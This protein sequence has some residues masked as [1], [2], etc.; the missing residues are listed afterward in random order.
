[1]SAG[2]DT[3]MYVGE[4]PWHNLGHKYE[5]AP[6]TSEEI[7]R[8]AS[9]DWTVNTAKM[10]T[11][12][13][14]DVLNYHAIYREDNNAI[15]GVVNTHYPKLV[16]NVESF[17]AF[18][19][20]LGNEVEV[21]TAAS[22]G[23]GER[24]FGCFKISQGY[25][26]IDDDIDHYLV[27]INDHLKTDGKVT[28]LNTPIRVVCQNTL[29][30]ALN[31]NSYKVRVPIYGDSGANAEIARKVIEGAGS[32]IK[33]LDKKA[34]NM[35]SQKVNRDYIEKLLDELF[36]YIK[37]DGDTTHSKAND[38]ADMMRETFL[39]ECM[40]ADNLGNY[41]GTQYQIFN[42][43]TDFSQHYFKNIDKAY[44]LNY[45]MGLLPGMGATDNPSNL[46]SKFLKIKDKLVA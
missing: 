33:E 35:L 7:I 32:C 38:I 9:L 5:V 30:H 2:I 39:S 21:D 31:N 22:L 36:P 45:R 8:A 3:M 10:Y 1:M 26:L 27:V 20:I 25:K 44:D 15:L 12:E 37:A 43:L 23:R 34:N 14:G 41:R 28:L 42:A 4:T 40:G 16:Q 18:E 17:K 29:S 46:V 6:R 13:H 19:S 11:A 24:V